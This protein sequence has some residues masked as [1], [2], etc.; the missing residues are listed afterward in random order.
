LLFNSFPR[1]EALMEN[2]PT[3]D[4]FSGDMDRDAMWV[5]AVKGLAA[6]KERMERIASTKPGRYFIFLSATHEILAHVETPAQWNAW[7]KS[8]RSV[9]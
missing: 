2:V 1:L 4:I 8:E 9:A 3:F 6:A 5:C 7:P